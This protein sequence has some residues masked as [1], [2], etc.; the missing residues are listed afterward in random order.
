MAYLLDEN[1]KYAASGRVLAYFAL[2]PGYKYRIN[3]YSFGN[4]EQSVPLK[5][6]SGSHNKYVADIKF[7]TGEELL[8]T[9]YE[10][11]A[12]LLQDKV[13]F[14]IDTPK[15]CYVDYIELESLETEISPFEKIF[16][17][18]LH[19]KNIDTSAVRAGLKDFAE[20]ALEERKL[21]P[22]F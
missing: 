17:E 5:F 19:T 2:I 10:F 22:R 20:L 4:T 7:D 1:H 8:K 9:S 14:R 11:T 18:M 13:G 15:G 16:G 21:S 12:S 6:E 3:V